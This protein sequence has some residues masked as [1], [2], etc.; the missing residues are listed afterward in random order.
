[1]WITAG[2]DGRH[3]ETNLIRSSLYKVLLFSQRTMTTGSSDL[4]SYGYNPITIIIIINQY[5]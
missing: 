5:Y 1:M 4:W 3:F 2:H